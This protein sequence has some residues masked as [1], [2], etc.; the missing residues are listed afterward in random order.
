MKKAILLFVFLV[1]FKSFALTERET[2]LLS[3]TLYPETK[4]E[5]AAYS[6]K[7]TDYTNQIINENRVS[8]AKKAELLAA[9]DFAIK[10]YIFK[11]NQFKEQ[12]KAF[13]LSIVQ[14]GFVSAQNTFSSL[15]RQD[16]I[17]LL[18]FSK[19]DS[20]SSLVS[21]DMLVAT[22]TPIAVIVDQS[23]PTISSVASANITGTSATITWTT[24]ETSDTQVEY[25][26]TA[27]YGAVSALN[28]SMVTTHSVSLTNLIPKTFYHYRIKS[29]DSAGNL[30]V[31]QDYTLT[32]DSIVVPTNHSIYYISPSGSDNNAG[33]EALPF[34]TFN[35]AFTT[36]VGGD[37][38]ILL[39][40]TYSLANGTGTIHWNNGAN[41]KQIPA[42]ISATEMTYVHAK[43]PGKVVVEGQL[44]IGRST[45]KDSY[46]KVQGIT[47]EG[48]GH[49]YNSDYSMIKDCGFHGPFSI[50][51]NDHH[52][53]AD[54]NLIE[55][56]WIW[57]SGQRIIA[58]NYRS[59]KNVWRR[60][61]VRG[62]G[63]GTVN[64]T[65][66]GNPNVGI[67]VY[68]SS[69][70]SLQNVMV[71]DRVLAVGDEPYGDFAVAQHTPDSRYY[72]GKNEWLGTLSLHSSDG[73]YHMEA[74]YGATV[75][76]T[77]KISN[78]VAWDSVGASFNISREG[79]N[80][81]FKN[82][83]AKSTGSDGVRLAPELKSGIIQNVI[84]AGA[85][86]FGINSV[87]APSNTDVFN[88]ASG[89]YNQTTC[90]T[91]CRTTN[92][93]SDGVTPSLKYLTRIES[94]SALKGA[95]ASGA[96]IG[97]NIIYRY[98]VDG[99]RFGE[100]GY[101]TLGTTPLWPWPNQAR[102][103]A[104]MC[105]NT[106]RGFC[107]AGKQLDGVRPVSLTSY[108]WEY[109]GNPVPVGIDDTLP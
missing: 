37:E 79:T 1:S 58:I 6:K 83:I 45:R 24:N 7:I 15:T 94:G 81:S 29:K 41:S 55:D 98:G 44:F 11:L 35:K 95:G 36:M 23:A 49:L 20:G 10:K 70:I 69:E 100:T 63:C 99:T 92:P 67:T 96:D 17:L 28:S 86:R 97:A 38:L 66:S 22:P 64:C 85:G 33:T 32:T 51:T 25:G 82:L 107:G 40:G 78:A 19:L 16:E 102:I 26:F 103:K 59:H 52:M 31:S 71:V 74:D 101:N 48:G 42:G 8:S 105:A 47:F 72:F 106:T 54:N 43:N 18:N 30:S 27:S 108:I 61:L 14:D 84:V 87:F 90:S 77:I 3:D 62:D 2:I 93:L 56:V 34:K 104:E 80:H 65:G 5:I 12:R 4:V 46:I 89:N 21:S 88:A 91:N 53:Y 109:L 75:D 68:D 60:V 73:G 76:P 9:R 13:L 39:D 50:G 57:A